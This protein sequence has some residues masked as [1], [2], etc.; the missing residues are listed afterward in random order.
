TAGYKAN[1][2]ILQTY[3][4]SKTSASLPLAHRRALGM[5]SSVEPINTV[6]C[7]VTIE[8]SP[9]EVNQAFEQA[10]RKL[11]KRA[12]IQGFRPGKAPLNVI[13]KLYGASVSAEVGENLVN[14]HRFSALQEKTIRPIAAPVLEKLDAPS[15]DKGF[16]FTALIDVM[17]TIDV[18]DYKG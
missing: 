16:H 1:N 2:L 12:K 18:G 6:Q 9:D 17:P 10:Y 15:Q 13:R 3:W 14:T 7:R 11:Q 4:R 5:K 8:V